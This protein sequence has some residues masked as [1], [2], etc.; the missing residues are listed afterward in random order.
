M[1]TENHIL[2]MRESRGWCAPQLVKQDMN[3]AQIADM[4]G[5]LYLRRVL[6]LLPLRDEE[7]KIKPVDGIEVGGR[8]TTGIRVTHKDWPAVNLYFDSENWLLV[9]IAGRYREA[10]SLN[11]REIIFSVFQAIDGV[12][13]PNKIFEIH[14]GTRFQE[15]AVEY[16]FPTRISEKEFEAP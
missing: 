5:E 9:K 1:G 3:D 15:C 4:Q 14:N 16:S 11:M 6:T 7:F 2:A 12:Q 10:G 13:T 8:K